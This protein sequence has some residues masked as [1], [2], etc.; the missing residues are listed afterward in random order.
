M[1]FGEYNYRPAHEVSQNGTKKSQQQANYLKKIY[2]GFST[3]L[4]EETSNLGKN[5]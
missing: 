5:Q 2:F 4:S 1:T 3:L